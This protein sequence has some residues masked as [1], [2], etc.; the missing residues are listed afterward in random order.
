MKQ[1]KNEQNHK[2]T[3]II[4]ETEKKNQIYG[5][6]HTNTATRKKKTK[7]INVYGTF[8]V[9]EENPIQKNDSNRNK[10]EQKWENC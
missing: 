2:A 1:Q 6:S 3:K 8:A 5:P 10:N 9:A 4:V 7:S